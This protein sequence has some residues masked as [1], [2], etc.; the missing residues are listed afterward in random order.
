MRVKNE[1]LLDDSGALDLSVNQSL[2]PLWLE[3][4]AY[5]SIQLVTTGAPVG[6]F[7]LQMSNDPGN[8]NAASPAN[9]ENI[10]N[11]TDVAD[12]SVIVSA[13]GN[14]MFD[15]SQSGASW[16]RVVWVAGGGSTGSLI[17]ARANTK[18]I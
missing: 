12:S 1:N 10:S 18:G 2:K 6:T 17:S 15:V 5:F 8:I 4:I 3:H 7:K 16:V 11:W 14:L 13:A 9:Q